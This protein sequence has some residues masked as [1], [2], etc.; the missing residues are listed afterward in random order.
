MP[1]TYLRLLAVVVAVAWGHQRRMLRLLQMIPAELP[2]VP[3]IQTRQMVLRVAVVVGQRVVR[4][5][6]AQVLVNRVGLQMDCTAE[7]LHL[8]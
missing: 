2:P 8:P 5:V 3:S 4:L 7:L 1:V 6:V